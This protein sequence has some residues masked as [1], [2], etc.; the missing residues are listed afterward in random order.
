L[1]L[2]S[3]AFEDCF[4]SGY[5]TELRAKL[6]PPRTPWTA[7]EF[8]EYVAKVGTFRGV[9]IYV[10]G[11]WRSLSS[12]SEKYLGGGNYDIDKV[13]LIRHQDPQGEWVET[14]CWK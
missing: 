5:Y 2:L 11:K 12:V 13:P 7:K 9:E 1:E 8:L 14:E 10:L 3:E 6:Q 4:K